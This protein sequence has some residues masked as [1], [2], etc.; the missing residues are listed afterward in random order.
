VLLLC[1]TLFTTGITLFIIEFIKY[2]KPTDEAL[3]KE[4]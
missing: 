4:E 1:A 3:V 2:G